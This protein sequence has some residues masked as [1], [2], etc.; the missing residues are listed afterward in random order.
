MPTLIKSP[1][2]N[3]NFWL[4]NTLAWFVL[5]A[6]NFINRNIQNV[7][8][9]DQGL[10]SAFGILLF[11]TL[12]SLL[13]REVSHRLDLQN[14]PFGSLWKYLIVLS[15]VIGLLCAFL[16]VVWASSYF[17][18]AGY[19]SR[20][21]FFWLNV[22]NNWMLMTILMFVWGFVYLATFRFQRLHQ[23][24]SEH[25][26]LK[27]SQLN[28][29]M[30]QLNPHFLFNGLNNIR[31]LML[32]DVDKARDMLTNLADVIRYSLLSQKNT[33]STLKEEFE[34]VN[35]YVEL[36]KIQYEER[37]DFVSEI[38]Q[39]LL[40][41]KVPTLLIQLLVENAVR[42]GIDRSTKGGVLNV[43][44]L[45]ENNNMIII[46]TNPGELQTDN[47]KKLESDR[48]S[49]GIGLENIKGRLK[50]L[51]GG[52]SHFELIE[53]NGKVTAKCSLPLSAHN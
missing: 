27:E 8:S 43:Q 4:A 53:D 20:F 19:S 11:G 23:I 36:A 42:H 18:L 49:T 32:E 47:R 34:I 5:A 51:Y 1:P 40:Q 29:L 46:V 38:D 30:G 14:K 41:Q 17:I 21:V 35:L 13:L 37:L 16:N 39:S 28:T 22:Q 6:I 26:R 3:K 12:C 48:N 2:T 7:E 9:V 50:L 33:T 52:D 24:E 45:S 25:R 31:S 10:F 44:V 15:I